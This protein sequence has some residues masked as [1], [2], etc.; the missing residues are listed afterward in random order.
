MQWTIRKKVVRGLWIKLVHILCVLHTLKDDL[1]DIIPV[2]NSL[3]INST[4]RYLS[5]DKDADD[6]VTLK[7]QKMSPGLL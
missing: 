1:K 6:P 4:G 5:K 7:Q 2:N 3:Q